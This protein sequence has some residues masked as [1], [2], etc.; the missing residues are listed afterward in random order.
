MAKGQH[1]SDKEQYSAYSTLSKR[2]N[3]RKA[4]LARHMKKH[5][6][7]A[8]TEA[9]A[10]TDGTQRQKSHVKGHFPEQKDILINSAGHKQLV[11]SFDPFIKK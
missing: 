7:D 11:G 9:A 10:K 3:N 6:N 8:Q 2:I 4:K 5:P 1:K